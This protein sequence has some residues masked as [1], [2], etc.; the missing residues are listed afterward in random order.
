MDQLNNNTL[1]KDI[2]R[3]SGEIEKIKNSPEYKESLKE[4]EISGK[5]LVKQTLEPIIRKDFSSDEKTP[6]SNANLSDYNS[7]FL[8]QYVKNASSDIK[9]KIEELINFVFEHG[10]EKAVKEAKKEGPFF[11][12]AFHDALADKLYEELKKRKLL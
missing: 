2:K 1:E 12:D 4:K 6:Q 10:V 7:S 9:N 3:I 5:E 8:P 11:L